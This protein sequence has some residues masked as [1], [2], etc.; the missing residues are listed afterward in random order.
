[1]DLINILLQEAVT[2][3]LLEAGDTALVDGN[4]PV[5]TAYIDVSGYH[6]FGFIVWAGALTSAVTAQVKQDTSATETASIKNI[7]DAAKVIAAT[8][9]NKFCIIEVDAAKMDINNGF[10]HVTLALSGGAGGDDYIGAMFFG[11]GKK[12]PVTN[13]ATQITSG[14]VAVV[15]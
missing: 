2:F 9:D 11:I 4:L 5:S 10:D 12:V 3:Q 1:M 8:D 7:T 6:R 13:G 15:G 14:L